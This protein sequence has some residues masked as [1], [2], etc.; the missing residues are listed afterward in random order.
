MA[1]KVK[2][3]DRVKIYDDTPGD[4]PVTGTVRQVNKETDKPGRLVGVELDEHHPRAH[5][6][7]RAIRKTV[8]GKEIAK[9][10]YGWWTRVANVQVIPPA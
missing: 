8:R 9:E 7:E 3:G 2:I 5:S 4:W 10:G 1:S 6:L